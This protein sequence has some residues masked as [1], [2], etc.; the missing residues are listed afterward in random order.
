MEPVTATNAREEKPIMTWT[1]LQLVIGFRQLP[2]D[3]IIRER[4]TRAFVPL[5]E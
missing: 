2:S 4:D 1:A 3:L 5:P